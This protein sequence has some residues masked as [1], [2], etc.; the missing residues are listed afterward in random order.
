[1][2]RTA[3][4]LERLA[5]RECPA[6]GHRRK[7]RPGGD[8]GPSPIV[9]ARGDGSTVVDAEGKTYLDLCAGFG[10]LV[11]GHGHPAWRAAVA[12]QLD[13]MV[14]GMGDVYATEPKVALLERLA[15]LHPRD[16]AQVLL[17]QSGGDAVTAGVKTAILATGR[18]RLIA[19]DGAYHGLGYAPLAACG[20]KPSFAAPFAPQ[21]GEHVAFVPYPGVRGAEAGESLEAIEAELKRGDVAAI[22]VEPILGRGGCVVPPD[23]FLQALG[24]V[25]HRYDALVVADEIW[26]GMG[27]SGAW[28]RMREIG[29]SVDVLCL[30]KALGGG[31]SIAAAV[32]SREVM[33]GWVQHGEVVHTSTHV[34]APLPC[35]AALA[36][37]DT[38]ASDDLVPRSRQLGEWWRQELRDRLGERVRDV[39]GAGLMVGIELSDAEVAQS[40]AAALLRRGFLALTGGVAGD[41]LTLTPP[42]TITEDELARFDIALDACLEPS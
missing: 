21:L 17:A 38:L 7:V 40:V 26:T 23:G 15:A 25:G 36:T 32:A 5:A 42:L 34:G 9:L 6:F 33:D 30:G 11:L 35:V 3:E 28:S 39:R 41:T 31:L 1:M 12:S 18:H 13:V 4:L 29:A 24:E 19:F 37:M 10:A 8:G 2:S 20:F 22:L 27:R 14:Q 16:D